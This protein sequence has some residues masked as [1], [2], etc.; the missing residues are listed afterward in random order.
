MDQSQLKTKPIDTVNEKSLLNYI[1]L[2]FFV[3]SLIGLPLFWLVG[4]IQNYPVLVWLSTTMLVTSPFLYLLLHRGY[5]L[6][7]KIF[8]V[9]ILFTVITFAT[10]FGF[11]SLETA[12]TGSYLIV[13]ATT[14]LLFLGNLRTI[15]GVFAA[16][17]LAITLLYIAQTANW[18]EIARP[19]TEQNLIVYYIQYTIMT[20]L[21]YY[22]TSRLH[23]T[24]SDLRLLNNELEKEVEARTKEL[25]K[26]NEIL[27]EQ[28]GALENANKFKAEIIAKANHE[29]RTPLTGLSINQ[30][31]LASGRHGEL[32]ARQREL[33]NRCVEDVKY[34]KH[35]IEKMLDVEQ[36]ANLTELRI[37][38][39][40]PAELEWMIQSILVAH[41]DK[42]ESQ[43][44]KTV[45]SV[46]TFPVPIFTD[47]DRIRQILT[48]LIDNAVK[49]TSKGTIEI[50]VETSDNLTWGI[51]VLDSGLG[52]SP[53]EQDEIFNLFYQAH[54]FKSSRHGLGLGLSI[55]KDLV[56]ALGGSIKVS[57][58]EGKG[59]QFLIT[60]PLRKEGYE[61]DQLPTHKSRNSK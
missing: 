55:V 44:V 25:I 60:L 38:E 31:L 40:T 20:G 46:G 27:Q 10:L 50:V 1:L 22:A 51:S 8:I 14:A 42:V 36:T 24:L 12:S 16:S 9:G 21:M 7:A 30:F 5:V 34:L 43:G 26:A 4:G 35:L 28:K 49:F 32:T 57:S 59:S 18:T 58:S 45:V 37:R 39:V 41:Q 53:S 3:L 29:L 33:L 17:L 47:P 2:F 54:A 23:A 61:N 6:F 11:G 13:I 56:N 19:T 52:I 48:N 15:L